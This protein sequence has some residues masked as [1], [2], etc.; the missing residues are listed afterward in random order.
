MASEQSSGE[1][2]TFLKRNWLKQ[3]AGVPAS[4]AS[5]VAQAFATREQLLEALENGEDLTNYTGVGTATARALWDWY[6]DVYNGVVEPD[7]TL[8]LDDDGLHLPD[9]LVGYVGTF[10][11]ETPS[12]TMR[13][14]T[15]DRGL[16]K[17]N[18]TLG[19]YPD[20]GDWNERLEAGQ[21]ALSTPG[22]EEQICDLDDQR[23]D[24]GGSVM[25]AGSLAVLEQPTDEALES[26]FRNGRSLP[27]LDVQRTQQS[28]EDDRPIQ[29]GK[30][31]TTVETTHRDISVG[32]NTDGEPIAIDV[33]R[34]EGREQLVTDWVADVTDTGL[35]V[36]ES[37]DGEG[38]L[39]FPFDVFWNVTGQQPERLRVNIA[40]LHEEWDRDG[41]LGDVWMT[42]ADI[43]GGAS[44]EYHDEADED[45]RPTIGMGFERPWSGKVMR[46]VV[47]ESGYCAIYSSS[48]APDVVRF[49]EEELLEFAGI[50]DDDEPAEEQETLDDLDTVSV[51]DGG[52]DA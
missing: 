32:V 20:D 22:H 51:A 15:T 37:T 27:A 7:G 47:Y 40:A 39:A 16:S 8:V 25:I 52:D 24:G 14:T 23:S 5:A 48:S 9:W 4:Q 30:A 29:S 10:T 49:L 12:I 42:S 43:G 41:V 35:I 50:P 17:V 38:E 33:D 28:L 1:D 46:G 11:V 3:K 19:V 26:W 45:A 36:A 44:I 21:I 34:Y 6:K 31:A 18:S 13:P 2:P